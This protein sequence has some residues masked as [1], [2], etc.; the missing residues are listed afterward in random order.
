MEAP[1]LSRT[2]E[3][4][5]YAIAD[6]TTDNT[7]RPKR[8]HDL[9]GDVGIDA[10]YSI[11]QNLTA[12]VTYNTD[13]AQVE[14]DEQQV[15]LTRFSLF[16]PEKRDFFLE[17][18]GLFTF[19]NNTFSPG[20]SAAASDLPVLFYSRRIGLAGSRE[21]PILGGGRVTGRVGRYSLGLIDMQTR[22]DATRPPAPAPPT[23]PSCA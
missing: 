11:T 3:L 23:S 20:A 22:P 5:P 2:L 4:K 19:G 17:N 6:V 16:F 14:A 10:K 9:S 21:V 1:P 18:Q 7:S 13:F 12:D 8:A 15:N